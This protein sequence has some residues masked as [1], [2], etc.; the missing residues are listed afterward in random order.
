[1]QLSEIGN[2]N[3]IYFIYT[4]VLDLKDVVSTLYVCMYKH[5]EGS[6]GIYTS[7]KAII[8]CLGSGLSPADTKPLSEPGLACTQR[9]P[10]DWA[11]VNFE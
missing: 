6:W 3:Q 1:M 7:I 9:E 5:I 2:F 10:K 4:F 8:I 11:S